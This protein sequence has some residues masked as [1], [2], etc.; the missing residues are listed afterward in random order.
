MALTTIRLSL[1]GLA[2]INRGD[3]DDF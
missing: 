1:I 3:F 2:L